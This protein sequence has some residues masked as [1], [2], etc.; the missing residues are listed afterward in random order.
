M[1]K[2]GKMTTKEIADWMGISYSGFRK[3]KKEKLETLRYFADFDEVYG[4]VYIK[5]IFQSVFDKNVSKDNAIYMKELRKTA[6]GISTCAGMTRVLKKEEVPPYFELSDT[7]IAKRLSKAGYRLFGP[8]QGNGEVG[9]RKMIWAI[10]LDKYNHYRELNDEENEILKELVGNYY[11]EKPDLILK[12]E[13]LD[14]EYAEN[15]SMSK[16]EYLAKKDAL[17]TKSWRDI[18]D[19][20]KVRTGFKLIH[21]TLHNENILVRERIDKMYN[22]S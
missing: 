14:R 13:L 17:N 12:N 21:A 5:E 3:R 4:G 15:S 16:E 6:N 20:F 1:L 9:N 11:S 8:Y 22:L 7:T 19:N 18:V 2:L 10:E